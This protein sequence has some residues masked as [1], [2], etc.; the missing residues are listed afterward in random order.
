M[1]AAG[2]NHR[3]STPKVS[4]G[5]TLVELLV[6]LVLGSLLT[7][8]M[9][10]V[11]LERKQQQR[12]EDQRARMQEGA[13]LVMTLLRRELQLAG[14]FAAAPRLR[15]RQPP[16][17]APGC[18]VGDGWALDPALPLDMANDMGA[19]APV[20]AGGL[21]LACITRDIQPGTDLLAIKRSAVLPALDDGTFATGSTG[22]DTPQWYLRS[23]EHAAAFDW[24]YL[25]EGAAPPA[26]EQLSGAGVAY[27]KA[28]ARL[29]FI[30]AYSVAGDGIPT[31]C[32]ERL[33]GESLG[34]LECLVP[35]VQDLQVG[36]GVDD[37]G[38]GVP[39]RYTYSPTAADLTQATVATVHLLMRSLEPVA[40]Q[41]DRRQY[42]LGQKTVMAP[43]DRFLRETYSFSVNLHNAPW[44][45]R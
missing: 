2:M 14:F 37:S 15:T 38:D 9:L 24:V 34:P 18:A 32:V 33:S 30:R 12:I 5:L 36:L 35:G 43:G 21:A 3:P 1:V 45:P 8:G 42:R 10:G 4:R 6:S 29:F 44:P 16:A 20:T 11:Y 27:W 23:R 22:L 7:L 40:T 19:G 26:A 28:R 31:L 41:R 17:G 25:P 13:R 39:E